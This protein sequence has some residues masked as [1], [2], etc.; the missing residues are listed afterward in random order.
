M[1]NNTLLKIFALRSI[2]CFHNNVCVSETSSKFKDLLYYQ[3]FIFKIF[4]NYCFD[5]NDANKVM[6]LTSKMT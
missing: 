5:C 6:I 3:L 2:K 1:V 4:L